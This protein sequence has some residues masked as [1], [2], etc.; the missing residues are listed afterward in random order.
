MSV[1]A[2]GLRDRLVANEVRSGVS[3]LSDRTWSV[4]AIALVPVPLTSALFV[5][6]SVATGTPRGAYGLP[7]AYLLYGIA[8][9]VTVGALYAL[10]TDAERRAVF[11]LSRP[12]ATELGWAVGA[13]VVGLGVFQLTSLV[14][15]ALGFE[16]QGLSYSLGDPTTL[17]IVV[18]G[19]VLIAPVTEEVLYRGLILG[20][21]LSRGYGVASAVALMTG[22]FALIHLPTFGVAGTLF[23]SVWGLLPAALR[24]RF[25]DLSGAVTL[26]TLNNAFA[27]VVVVGLGLN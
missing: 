22:L 21:L 19:A 3:S 13:F 25:D 10:L 2:V 26:H 4:V 15:G 6:H 20:V 18:L 24:L 5:L 11:R 1:V 12:S 14:S 8:N 9:V 16:L 23:I 17:V 27:Y 7:M